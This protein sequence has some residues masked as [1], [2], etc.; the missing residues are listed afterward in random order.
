MMFAF[1]LRFRTAKPFTSDEERLTVPADEH[2]PE[3]SVAATPEGPLREAKWLSVRLSGFD[4]AEAACKHA[5]DLKDRLLLLGI[6]RSMGFDFGHDK[7]T[8]ALFSAFRRQLEE[9]S[10]QS[11]RDNVH[12]LDVFEDDPERDT[13]FFTINATVTVSEPPAQ[14][15][16]SFQRIRAARLVFSERQRVA[17]ELINDSLFPASPDA[18]LLIR[19]AAM[20][21]LCSAGPRPDGQQ[22]LLARLIEVLD[23]AGATDDD[24]APLRE[25]LLRGKHETIGHAC[26]R[27]V[28]DLLGPGRI[29]EFRQVYRA[30]SRLVHVGEGRGQNAA[31]AGTALTLALAL[32][33]ADLGFSVVP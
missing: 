33:A 17:L 28:A 30:R 6:I 2:G 4:S 14:F 13:R 32:V 27:K 7:I 10:G 20:E 1:R 25:M 5:L 11:I 9:T 24:K 16:A 29:D 18:Q 3:F 12:G 15:V 19:V 31:I 21:V 26:R 22:V 23:A 8:S